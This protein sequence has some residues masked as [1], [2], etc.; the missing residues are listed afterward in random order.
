V[1]EAVAVFRRS[2]TGSS[3][4]RRRCDLLQTVTLVV[5][6]VDSHDARE[7]LLLVLVGQV[8]TIAP[9]HDLSQSDG[10]HTAG[11]CGT[12]ALH[13]LQ[14][15]SITTEHGVTLQ[16]LLV[17]LVGRHPD[18]IH[19]IPLDDP[20]RLEIASLL[21]FHGLMTTRALRPLLLFRFTLLVCRVS[22]FLIAT[23]DPICTRL[24][25]GNVDDSVFVR[26]VSLSAIGTTI[27]HRCDLIQAPHTQLR[28]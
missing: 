18:E 14:Q 2:E 22:L 5:V 28:A 8:S 27:V 11:R 10:T 20:Q 7:R 19:E 16:Q 17:G 6:S 24:R 21:G 25:F 3:V 26:V 12:C 9:M 1:D 23:F 15:R 4:G 13:H